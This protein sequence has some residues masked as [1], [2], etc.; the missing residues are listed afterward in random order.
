MRTQTLFQK[1]IS[2]LEKAGFEFYVNTENQDDG[3]KGVIYTNTKEDSLYSL[4]VI[5]LYENDKYE[6]YHQMGCKCNFKFS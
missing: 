6:I 3:C 2:E 4:E 5:D 1:R